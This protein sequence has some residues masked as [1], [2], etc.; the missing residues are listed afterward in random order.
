VANDVETVREAKRLCHNGAVRS[1]FG[2]AL[3]RA[4][5]S[6]LNQAVRQGRCTTERLRELKAKSWLLI[7]VLLGGSTACHREAVDEAPDR[8]VQ[9]FIERTKSAY[10]DPKGAR[11]AFE[12]LWSTAQKNLTERAA[13]AS[14]LANRKVAPE[15]MLALTKL[16]LRF[17][18]RRYTAAIQGDMAVVAVS[19]DNPSG[20]RADIR[21]VRE[22]GRWRVVIDLPPLAPIQRR[23]DATSE[24]E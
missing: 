5:A 7:P 1:G 4:R 19:G 10:G 8:L 13:R 3:V 16:S 21:C 11:A 23:P 12:L 20:D 18:P 14:A 9:E 6:R 17:V 22:Q 15:E 2:V 24:E